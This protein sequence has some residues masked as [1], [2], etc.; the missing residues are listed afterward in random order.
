MHYVLIKM[1]I[2][3]RSEVNKRGFTESYAFIVINLHLFLIII[4]TLMFGS[5]IVEYIQTII[6]HICIRHSVIM[7]VISC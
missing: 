1:Y 2:F 4:I 3:L 6:G 7:A 5:I